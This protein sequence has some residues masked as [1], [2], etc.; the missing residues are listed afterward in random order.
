MG[1]KPT[2]ADIQKWNFKKMIRTPNVIVTWS[3]KLVLFFGFSGGDK[4]VTHLN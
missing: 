4:R 3:K 2:L 1:W